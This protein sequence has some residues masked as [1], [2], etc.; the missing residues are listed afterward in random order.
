MQLDCPSQTRLSQDENITGTINPSDGDI[1]PDRR[2][3]LDT[4]GFVVPEAW[5]YGGAEPF[6]NA[7]ALPGSSYC[8]RHRALCVVPARSAKGR[9][10]ARDLERLIDGLV[11]VPEPIEAVEAEEILALLELPRRRGAAEFE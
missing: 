4:C 6:C 11:S 9:G 8:A 2:A 7:P 3:A 5:S 10:L 1:K